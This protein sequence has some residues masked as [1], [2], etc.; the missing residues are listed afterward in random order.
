MSEENTLL[1][2][3]SPYQRF[4]GLRLI[5]A[6]RIAF[7]PRKLTIAT[8]GLILLQAGWSLLDVALPASADVTPDPLESIAS[9]ASLFEGWTKLG[10]SAAGLALRLIEPIRLLMTPLQ[11]L[12]DP[13]SGWLT[14]FHALLGLVWLFV[15]WG[16]CGGAIARLGLVQEAQIRQ[17]G[18]VE[19][20][21]FALRS[22]AALILA[23]LCPLFAMA[24]CAIIGVVFGLLYRVPS[25]D[26]VA[27]VGLI[28]P[29]VAGLIM[30]LL[31]VGLVAGWP[32]LHA[33]MAA[34]ADNT[35]DALSRTFSYLNQRLGL[36][37]VGVAMAL[38]AGL[39]GLIA[40]DLL[41]SGVIRLT[42][43]SLSLSG[44][45]AVIEALFGRSDLNTG[46]LATATHR[47]WLRQCAWWPPHGSIATSGPRRHS[48]TFGSGR[49]LTGHHGPWSTRSPRSGDRY[50]FRPLSPT[51]RR[52]RP[53]SHR[54]LKR[55]IDR[56]TRPRSCPARSSE[57]TR[58][59]IALR[60]NPLRTRYQ[61]PAGRI[62]A[63][64]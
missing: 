21:R 43:W 52:L 19:G 36:Y 63:G 61:R 15:I 1:S 49:K 28:I 14:M 10:D 29:L 35:L 38:I 12:L 57:V 26:V 3:S 47:F 22:A 6:I 42:Q 46:K 60:R 2:R 11:L 18:I 62:P 58:R 7:D 56:P 40:V 32:L 37:L 17:P 55:E 23:P 53:R 25:G 39:V 51:N 16:I 45:R 5:A 24:F 9:S 59:P 44:D 30:T 27:G 4:G 48:S 8:L 13:S 54:L 64:G 34:G 41:A 20:V 33:A 50:P 31:V